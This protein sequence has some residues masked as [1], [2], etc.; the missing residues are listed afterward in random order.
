MED[1]ALRDA[2]R[3]SHAYI[4]AAPSMAEAMRSARRIAAAAVC[5]GPAPRP[6]GQ[7]PACRKVQEDIHPDVI[8]VRRL[9]DDKGRPKREITVDQ[10]RALSAD[11]V[12]LPNEA[13]RKVYLIE[14]ADRMNL[15][16][17]NAA[18]KLLEEPPAGVHFVLCAI[19]PM[20]LLPTVRSR[21]AELLVNGEPE[22]AE[23][24]EAA[25]AAEF[26][27]L[28]ARGDRAELNRWCCANDGLD[29]RG[30]AA[31]VESAVDQAA[32]MLCGR[33]P[34][35]GLRPAQLLRLTALLDRCAEYLRVNVNVKLLFGL[36]AVDAVS[37]G[38]RG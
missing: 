18:L 24:A 11:A 28:V 8:T 12:V 26:L 7:C 37:D 25:L 16:A 32:D 5:T 9:P 20:Q 15:N 33:R 14:D 4:V 31:F 23:G 30:A 2:A 3:L 6:C 10:I 35:L 1:L 38:N 36:L 29:L 34:D 22:A 17:Q 19:N 27:Q 21:C 13:A